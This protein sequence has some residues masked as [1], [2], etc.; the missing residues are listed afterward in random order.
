MVYS[1]FFIKKQ[2]KIPTILSLALVFAVS[3]LLGRLVLTPG[4]TTRAVKQNVKRVEIT[5]ILSNQAAVVWQ[6]DKKEQGW[7][8]FGEDLN[9]LSSLILDVRDSSDEKKMFLNHYVILKNLK[10]DTTYYFKIASNDGLASSQ[11]NE[12]FSFKTSKK[13]ANVGGLKPAYGKVVEKDGSDLENAL[14]LLSID[15]SIP[16]S[17]LSKASGEWLIPLNFVFD[18]QTTQLKIL[19]GNEKAKL[20]IVSEEGEDSQVETVVSNLNPLSE[21]VV[22]GRDYSLLEKEEVLGRASKDKTQNTK[23]EIT[24]PKANAIIPDNKP[25]IKGVAA[26]GTNLQVSVT[27]DKSK[28]T[29]NIQA[30]KDGQ[31]RMSISSPLSAGRHT[32]EVETRGV[33]GN[34]ISQRREF[35]VAKSGEQVLGEATDEPTPQPTL[36]ST[37]SPSVAKTITSSPTPPVSGSNLNNLTIASILFIVIGLGLFFYGLL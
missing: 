14:I 34:L 22:I 10:D 16:L 37:P 9:N 30:D 8:I 24:Y 17:T 23:L 27:D 21:T 31:W 33:G 3:Y 35:T 19:S 25:L 11:G 6:T 7:L 15:G 4:K 20:E 5:N 12:P 2:I 26:A 29:K 13:A 32:L 36:T 18:P 1:N 28:T